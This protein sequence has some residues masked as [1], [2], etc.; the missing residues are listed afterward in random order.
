MAAYNINAK[1][2]LDSKRAQTGLPRVL[3]Q[4]P[5]HKLL[6]QLRLSGKADEDGQLVAEGC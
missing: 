2:D 5:A 3:Q 1:I 4:V 6:L